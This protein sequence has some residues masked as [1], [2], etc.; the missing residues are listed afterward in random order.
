MIKDYRLPYKEYCLRRKGLKMTDDRVLTLFVFVGKALFSSMKDFNYV[1]PIHLLP[2][3]T[4]TF[5]AMV[6]EYEAYGIVKGYVTFV[7]V[8]GRE[9]FNF[10]VVS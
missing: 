10:S 8:I 7:H 2:K 9:I 5:P 1:R 6:W 3:K 4:R